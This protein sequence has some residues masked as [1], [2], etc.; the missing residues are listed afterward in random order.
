MA[1]VEGEKENS[2][3]TPNGNFFFLDEF[4]LSM[5][6]PAE[7]GGKVI[8]VKGIVISHL[9]TETKCKVIKAIKPVG[10]SL[11]TA[12]VIVGEALRCQAAYNAVAELV[13]GG[14][15]SNDR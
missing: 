3:A 9:K 15:H 4:K 6:I 12:V 1:S 5:W 8:G 10:S 13:N 14:E 2:K 11:W 7:L